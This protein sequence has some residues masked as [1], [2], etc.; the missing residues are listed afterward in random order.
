M[1][2]DHPRDVLGQWL[3][4]AE[5][6]LAVCAAVLLGVLNTN[7]REPLAHGTWQKIVNFFKYIS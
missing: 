2:E 7:V 3:A 5:Q 1:E 6:Q 4:S